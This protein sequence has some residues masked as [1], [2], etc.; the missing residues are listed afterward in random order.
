MTYVIDL[1]T[2]Q[3]FAMQFNAILWSM[4]YEFLLK[5]FLVLSR[6]YEHIEYYVVNSVKKV[7]YYELAF[8]KTFI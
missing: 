1:N 7:K 6:S 5:I 8:N 2:S 4:T 3:Y